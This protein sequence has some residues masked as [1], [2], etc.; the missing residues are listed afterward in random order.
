V[1]GGAV[2]G[3]EEAHEQLIDSLKP[4]DD[5]SQLLE[6]LRMARYAPGM[7]ETVCQQSVVAYPM[8]QVDLNAPVPDQGYVVVDD[9]L[10]G[11][12]PSPC[13]AAAKYTR[14]TAWACIV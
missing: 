11:R 10:S 12:Q 5:V 13:M 2:S 9:V 4:S 6:L 3:A 14:S 7:T 8:C 1:T